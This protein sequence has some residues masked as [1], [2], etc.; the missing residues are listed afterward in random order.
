MNG[1]AFIDTNIFVYLYSEDEI[2]KRYISQTT[3]DNYECIISTQVLNEFCNVCIRKLNKSPKEVELAIN[4]IV[5]Q[6]EVLM[7]SEQS[8]KKALEIYKKYKYRY[9]DCLM[10]ASA[11]DSDCKYLITEDMAD[12]QIIEGK[13]TILNIYENIISNLQ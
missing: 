8:I 4:E 12:G 1:K 2:H 13:L 6:C 3:V 5:G 7:I 11:L 9:F 10:V